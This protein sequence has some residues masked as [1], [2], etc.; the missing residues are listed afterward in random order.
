MLESREG[1][2]Q[3]ALTYGDEA[4]ASK[5]SREE[6]ATAINA[7]FLIKNLRHYFM[8]IRQESVASRLEDLKTAARTSKEMLDSSGALISY[9]ADEQKRA[10]KRNF[11][12]V[13]EGIHVPYFNQL[14]TE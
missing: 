5:P 12:C 11:V 8:D 7:R 6:T 2:F 10:G 4:L 9:N 1:G 3:L 14:R 13:N